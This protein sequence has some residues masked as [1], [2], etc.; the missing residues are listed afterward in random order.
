LG[1][2]NETIEGLGLIRETW[3]NKIQNDASWRRR[4][5][6]FIGAMSKIKGALQMN[7]FLIIKLFPD[8]L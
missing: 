4:I 1:A 2:E 8:G 7:R 6:R 3:R 5:F